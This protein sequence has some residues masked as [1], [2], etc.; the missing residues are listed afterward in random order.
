MERVY[1]WPLDKVIGKHPL[2]FCPDKPYWK[3]LSAK[4]W[5]SLSREGSWDGVVMNV[6]AHGGEFPILLRVRLI[7]YENVRYSV[8]WARLKA[9]SGAAA[10]VS[11]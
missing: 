3:K 1:G 2:K 9:K 5:E 7:I 6:N 8:S 4:I 11:T 10:S